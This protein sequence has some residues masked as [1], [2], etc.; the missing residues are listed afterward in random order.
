ML[1]PKSPVSGLQR[2]RPY[3]S[4]TTA[5]TTR[6][7]F[8]KFF[9]VS[10]SSIVTALGEEMRPETKRFWLICTQATA[11]CFNC[12]SKNH[13][14]RFEYHKPAKTKKKRGAKRKKRD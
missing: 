9:M 2:T 3:L 7:S 14:N 4:T 11:S 5:S 1:F 13:R 12:S 8:K 10:T 6:G